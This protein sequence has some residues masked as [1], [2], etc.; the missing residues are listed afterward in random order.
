MRISALVSLIIVVFVDVGYSRAQAMEGDFKSD[1]VTQQMILMEPAIQKEATAAFD[2]LY[3]LRYEE[4]EEA[5]Y[6]L[7]SR[8]E[9]HPL[10]HFLLG[11]SEWWKIMPFPDSEE[12]D[13]TFYQFMDKSIDKAEELLDNRPEYRVEAAFF[14]SAAYSFKGQ[15]YSER[16]N[17]GKATGAGKKGLKYYKISRDLREMSPELLFGEAVYNYYSVWI[18]EKYPPMKPLFWFFRT[19]DKDLGVEQLKV[20]SKEALFTKVEAQL[21]LWRILFNE[22][23]EREPALAI[24]RGLYEEYPQNAVFHEQFTEMLYAMGKVEEA[25]PHAQEIL[26]R[27]SKN[28]TGYNKQ[29]GITGSFI[30]G[31]D[32]KYKGQKADAKQKFIETMQFGEEVDD[33]DN[34]FYLL[35]AVNMVMFAHEEGNTQEFNRYLKVLEDNTKRKHWARKQLQDY[36]NQ[37]PR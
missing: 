21:F 33:R 34:A 18:P 36:L 19:G 11:L 10:P 14:L 4:A 29:I 8:Y 28:Q 26:N 3:N 27:V 25:S 1:G 15:L 31:M 22:K 9:W 13:A 23:Q 35:S 16:G 32:M 24:T 12:F 20:V 17:W 5:F 30:L 2:D 6:S 37:N 7:K